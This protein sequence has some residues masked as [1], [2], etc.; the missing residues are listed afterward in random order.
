MTKM[1]SKLALLTLVLST[2]VSLAGDW[3]HWRGPGYDGISTETIKI[4][5]TPKTL[6]KAKAGIGFSSFSVAAGRVFTMGHD[7]SGKDTV[8][9]FD[10]ASGKTIWSHGYDSDLGDKYFEGGTTGTPTVDG[11][12]VFTLSRWGD[13]FCLDV[14]T[15]KIVWSKNVR[16]EGDLRIPDWGYSGSPLVSGTTLLLNMGESGVALDK[17]TGKTLWM[18]KNKDAGY[19]TP[20][21]YLA[22]GKKAAILG[23]G[24]AYIAVEIAT[25]NVVWSH[26]WRTSY[27]VN[28]ADPI[29]RDGEAFI[30]SGYEKGCALLKLGSNPP[31]VVWTNKSMRNQMSPSLLVDGH[32]YGIDGNESKKPMLKCLDWTTGAEKWSFPDAGAGT[33]AGAGDQL[34]VLSEKGELCIGKASPEGF[35]PTVRMQILSGRC[36]TV[37]VVSHG[38]L[39]CR[40]AAGD[41]VCLDVGAK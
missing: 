17:T 29:V 21:P 13:V 36:W 27:G 33:V 31:A 24:R 16:Q 15:G 10:A 7:G 34:I 12:R 1:K 28:A 38:R 19:S 41:V 39:Y 6:W 9:C 11:E 26:D 30:S 32:L 35:K 25:G 40:N 37:P 14:A 4:A 5:G 22:D 3:P 20:Y 23:S 18:S 2:S 8:W